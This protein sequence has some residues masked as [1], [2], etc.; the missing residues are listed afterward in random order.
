MGVHVRMESLRLS[1]NALLDSLENCVSGARHFVPNVPKT[2]SAWHSLKQP[3][4]RTSAPNTRK[5]IPVICFLW[6]SLVSTW[7][8][9]YLRTLGP[10]SERLRRTRKGRWRFRKRLLKSGIALLQT[11]FALIPSRSIQQILANVFWSWFLKTVSKFRKRKRKS[12]SC[13]HV[14]HKTAN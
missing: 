12:F 14:L 10:A 4:G 7:S 5:E 8:S 3:S 13:A 11:L 6:W 1:V 9:G 2:L